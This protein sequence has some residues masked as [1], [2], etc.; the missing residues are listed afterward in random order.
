VSGA[1]AR[2]SAAPIDAHDTVAPVSSLDVGG[3]A[4]AA[5]AG[6]AP[7]AVLVYAALAVLMH[8]RWKLD[9]R[10]LELRSAALAFLPIRLAWDDMDSIVVGRR[11][12]P[13]YVALKLD[14][15]YLF[16]RHITIFRR[17]GL[18]S[19][20]R[21]TPIDVDALER[22]LGTQLATR[23]GWRPSTDGWVRG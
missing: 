17:T 22:A 12:L 7:L 15:R 20:V 23:A 4:C 13:P 16:E 3:L 19:V 21:W 18:T 6:S 5:L 11:I 8:T 2:G 9:A 1:S 10:G 14:G